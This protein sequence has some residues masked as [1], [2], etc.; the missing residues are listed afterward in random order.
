M[1]DD[2]NKKNEGN[3]PDNKIG[4]IDG[5]IK[6]S[7]KTESNHM[8]WMRCDAIIKGWLTTAMEKEI[9]TSVKYANTSAEIWSD[10]RERFGKESAPRAY[11]LKQAISNTRQDGLTVSTYYTKLRGLWDGIQSVLPTPRCSCNKCECGLGK[12]LSE[13]KEKERLYE[14]L[15]GLDCEFS[16]VRTQ[17]LAMNPTPS[18]RKWWPRKNKQK[19]GR[20]KAAHVEVESIPIEGLTNDQYEWF[21][22]HF[23]H[24]ETNTKSN[25]PQTANMA[26]LRQ[27]VKFRDGDRISLIGFDCDFVTMLLYLADDVD[28]IEAVPVKGRGNRTLP[29]EA[30]VKGVLHILDFNCNLLSVSKLSSDLRCVVSFFPDFFVIQDLALRNLI[31]ADR[32]KNGLYWMGMLGMKRKALMTKVDI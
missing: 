23:A 16:I 2:N 12:K 6:K 24:E 27:V 13:L 22:K 31:G 18:L 7:E 25:A 21:L 32:C 15:I 10:L 4:F 30:K 29:D 14:F 1:A 20:P 9:R 26:G 5:T 11:E 19:K 28:V 17:I 8:A 3:G